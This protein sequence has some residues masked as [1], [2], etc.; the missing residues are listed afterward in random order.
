M[1]PD[2]TEEESF[3]KAMSGSIDIF[4]NRMMS[5]HQRGRSIYTDSSVQTL[6]QTISQMH[7]QL[8]NT[9]KQLEDQRSM[10]SFRDMLLL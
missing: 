8:V 7:P 2:A 10:F 6:F 3:I 9:T 4:I 1:G 5:D